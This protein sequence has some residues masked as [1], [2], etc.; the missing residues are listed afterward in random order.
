MSKKSSH[1]CY[2][3]VKRVLLGA[4]GFFK[5]L[6]GGPKIDVC[7]KYFLEKNPQKPKNSH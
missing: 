4:F 2:V 1:N 3:N 6:F 5:F 7:L